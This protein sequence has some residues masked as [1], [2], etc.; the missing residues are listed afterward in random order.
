LFTSEVSAAGVRGALDDVETF[1]KPIL[2][3]ADQMIART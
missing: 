3:A 2:C 1:G